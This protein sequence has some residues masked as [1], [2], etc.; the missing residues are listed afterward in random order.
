MVALHV[1]VVTGVNLVMLFNREW[2]FKFL[3]LYEFWLLLFF[4]VA[5]VL[6]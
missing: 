2:E 5:V 4:R 1:T 3:Y 6:I